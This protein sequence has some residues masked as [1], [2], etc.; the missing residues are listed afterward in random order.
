VYLPVTPIANGGVLET[1]SVT[2]FN[3]KTDAHSQGQSDPGSGK[4]RWNT[5][6]QVNATQIYF[7][8]LT[9]DGF[10]ITLQ[11]LLLGPASRI[12]IQAKDFALDYQLWSLASGV[13]KTKYI[14]SGADF[15]IATVTLVES[16][17][18]AVFS[19]NE[20]VAMLR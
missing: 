8:R 14:T 20:A 3:F 6:G 11:L 19:H 18:N 4:I 15:F 13:V 5:A 2:I 9:T 10:D 17:G 7:D 16:N 1:R 12:A